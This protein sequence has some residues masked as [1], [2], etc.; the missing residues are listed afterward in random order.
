VE[1]TEKSHR[2]YLLGKQKRKVFSW[3][4]GAARRCER[5]NGSSFQTAV[6]IAAAVLSGSTMGDATA[7]DAVSEVSVF[8]KRRLSVEFRC[9]LCIDVQRSRFIL[10]RD[11]DNFTVPSIGKF[12]H[13]RI[14]PLLSSKFNTSPRSRAMRSK[15]FKVRKSLERERFSNKM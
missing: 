12:K 9:S 15:T 11:A 4:Q 3:I 6:A 10:T 5:I 1:P 8:S 2:I 13:R 7:V 14:N